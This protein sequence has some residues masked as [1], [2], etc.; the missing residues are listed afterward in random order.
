MKLKLCEYL[1][2]GPKNKNVIVSKGVSET[3]TS[4]LSITSVL[5]G[6]SQLQKTRGSHQDYITFVLEDEVTL[7]P[8]F[9]ENRCGL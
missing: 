3:L 5:R 6:G 2:K 7:I 9:Q 8:N 4:T 1:R